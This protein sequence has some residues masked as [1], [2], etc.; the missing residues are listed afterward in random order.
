MPTRVELLAAL[1]TGCLAAGPL[2]ASDAGP[3]TELLE[4]LGML[5]STDGVW[6]DP[7]EVATARLPA[8]AIL[9]DSG[10]ATDPEREPV[11]PA[12]IDHE[13]VE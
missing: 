1:L 13:P 3:G 11:E 10:P 5:V 2:A 12:E 7:M 4:F 6:I 9:P 8:A